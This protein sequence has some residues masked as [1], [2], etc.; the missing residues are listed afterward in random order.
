VYLIYLISSKLTDNELIKN[1]LNEFGDY[2]LGIK[3]L[4]TNH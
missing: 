1:Q 4:L 3:I 2:I